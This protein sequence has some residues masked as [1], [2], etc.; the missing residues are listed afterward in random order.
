MIKGCDY[1]SGNGSPSLSGYDFAF[2]K[3]TEGH[4]GTDSSYAAQRERIRAAGLVF[5]AYH[6]G[7]QNEGVDEQARH[8]VDVASPAAGD[9]LFLDF[10]GYPD[11]RNW[12][13]TSWRERDA[14]RLAWIS[15]VRKLTDGKCRVGTYCD[16]SD[17]FAIPSDD[18]GDFLFIAHYGVPKPGVE[19]AWRFWQHGDAPID[20]DRGGFASAAALRKWAGAA[21]REGRLHRLLHWSGD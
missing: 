11:G 8:F 16:V 14:W 12:S 20:Q 18:P 7:W 6:F 13:G 17:W 1:Y 3:A 9:V 21:T 10:E 5:G 19:H 2:I 15:R 4:Q